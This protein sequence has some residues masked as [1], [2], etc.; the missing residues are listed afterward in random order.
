M[1]AEEMILTPVRPEPPAELEEEYKVTEAENYIEKRIKFAQIFEGVKQQR[2]ALK[3][4]IQLC[5][6]ILQVHVYKNS[7]I[8]FLFKKF[9]MRTRRPTQ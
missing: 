5:C 3:A 2:M 6:V 4:D 7:I 8:V 1:A 9:S